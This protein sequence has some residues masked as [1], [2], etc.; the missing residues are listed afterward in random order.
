MWRV[1]RI[2]L[3]GF[4][5]IASALAALFSGPIAILVWI[6]TLAA[7]VGISRPRFSGLAILLFVI[8]ELL[9]TPYGYH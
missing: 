4:L 8:A 1:V 7:F 5:V 6:A 9:H 3:F 2:A